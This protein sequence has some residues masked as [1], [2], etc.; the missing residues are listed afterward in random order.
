MNEIFGS[1]QLQNVLKKSQYFSQ[2]VNFH[3]ECQ[4]ENHGIKLRLEIQ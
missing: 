1:Y 3:E 2:D 4:G